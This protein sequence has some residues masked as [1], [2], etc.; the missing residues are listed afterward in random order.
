M[1]RSA[2]AAILAQSVMTPEIARSSFLLYGGIFQC[3]VARF[4]S[5]CVA[6]IEL[7]FSFTRNRFYLLA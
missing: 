6:L 3:V 2:W 1:A 7:Y 4:Q 5:P